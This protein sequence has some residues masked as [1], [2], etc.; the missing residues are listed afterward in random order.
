MKTMRRTINRSTNSYIEIDNADALDCYEHWPAPAA[1]IIDGPYGIGGFPGDPTDTV[2]LPKWYAP[3]IA[4]WSKAALPYTTLWFWG[5]ELGWSRVNQL[6][7]LNGWHYE[8]AFVW[9]KG[10][11][12]AAGN[13]NSLTIRRAPV[14]TEICV[15]YTRDVR[16][17]NR[18]GEMLSLQNWLRDE[19]SMTGLPFSKTNEAC[20]IKN[21]ATRKYFTKDDLWY[22]PPAETLER[23]VAYANEFGDRQ[24]APFFSINGEPFQVET[25]KLM[26]AKWNHLHGYTNVWDVPSLHGKERLKD[27]R[28]GK[29][30]HYN[31][32]PS[33][34]INYLINTTSDPGDVIWD[35]FA[36]LATVAFCCQNLGRD[37]YCSEIN[38]DTFDVAS[39]RIADHSLLFNVG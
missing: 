22:F 23:I 9:N 20:G 19:W 15:R 36:G 26:R 1:I 34:I 37:C 18:G 29:S 11:G 21:A 12:H 3:H 5:T 16:L 4:A 32:K 10:M 8:Q 38:E 24:C 28:T 7:E 6:L 33:E 13:V 14:V 17:P 30:I 39:N 35:P 31:Q 27:A 2:E 25:W